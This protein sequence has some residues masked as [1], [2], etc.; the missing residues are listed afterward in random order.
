MVAK[1]IL[2]AFAAGGYKS[3]GKKVQK[4]ENLSPINLFIGAN[5]SGKSNVLSFIHGPLKRLTETSLNLDP[6]DRHQIGNPDFVI[7]LSHAES[8]WEDLI[9][10][11]LPTQSGNNPT[12]RSRVRQIFEMKARADNSD[13]AWTYYDDRKQLYIK[14]WISALESIPD[15]ELYR[16]W[17]TLNPGSSGGGRDQHWLPNIIEKV[18]APFPK[19]D[20]VLI[21][22]IRK[23]DAQDVSDTDFSGV[24]LIT[25]LAQLQNPS[26]LE[27]HEKTRFENINQFLQVVTNNPTAELEIPF[28]RNTI[29]VNMDN[30]TLP[31]ESL[32]TGIH[33][34][35]ILAA[36]ST[37]LQNH[38][39]CLEEPEIHLHPI[40][41]KQLI[42]YLAKNT[43]NQY[44]ISTHSAAFMDTPDAKIFHITIYD[45][46]SVAK[47]VSSD[48]DKSSVCKDLGYHPSDLFQANC[49]I[50]VE[51]PSDRIYIN[52]WIRSQQPS[53]I[54]GIHYSIM[55]YGGRLASHLSGEDLDRLVDNFISLRR[56]NRRAA[57]V[58][59]SD[60][61][62][63]RG[64]INATKKRL[65]DEF[66]G[67]KG[68]AWVTEGKEI[69][70]YLPINQVRDAIASS[71]PRQAIVSSSGKYETCLRIKSK[72]ERESL[73]DKVK[74]A[75]YI[76]Q[77]YEPDL[78]IYDLRKNV[79]ALINFISDSNPRVSA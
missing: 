52:Y 27:R 28:N 10:K 61:K 16:V 63:P 17:V 38:V 46:E 15:E 26:A 62:S 78:S 56:L 79:R 57:I 60:K 35:I 51:G 24:G 30:K 70:N 40:L 37:I 48:T 58:I 50:W 73:A 44:F 14:N 4:F 66:G 43:A 45:G 64:R 22:A 18:K 19:F 2:N 31:L 41:Q 74:V 8:D 29:L 34:V 36:A 55:F 68:F 1:T 77:N 69:E 47:D 71:H 75:K 9:E 76:V 49:I 67:E 12:I 39:V 6:L 25:K 3:F 72:K 11:L 32:G 20:A 7:G 13:S 5:N 33:D 23:I 21:P 54:E 59:D 65:R 42:R 53:L